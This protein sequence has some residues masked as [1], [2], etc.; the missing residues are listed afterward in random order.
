MHT[1]IIV[2]K[3]KIA[4]LEGGKKSMSKE[5][6]LTLLDF[7]INDRFQLNSYIS[8][9]FYQLTDNHYTKREST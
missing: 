5:K 7:I 8:Y 3:M 6:K 4:K 9:L 2:R 1:R